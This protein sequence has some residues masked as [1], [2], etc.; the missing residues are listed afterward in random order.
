MKSAQQAALQK[1][2]KRLVQPTA[3]RAD[4]GNVNITTFE[5]YPSVF[6]CRVG[7]LA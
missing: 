5:H 7:V 2:F 1:T 6:C 4:R 3:Q